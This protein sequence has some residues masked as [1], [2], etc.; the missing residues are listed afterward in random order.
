MTRFLLDISVTPD[1]TGLPSNVVGGL[2]HLTN[3]AA[4]LLTLVS[5]LGVVIS[6]VGILF[7]NWTNNPQL[8]ERAK[9][10]FALSVGCIALLYV[11][12]AAANYSARLFA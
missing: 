5:G 11:G 12:I 3:N 9:S 4:A 1:F 2:V 7:A 8:S 6:L 10:G